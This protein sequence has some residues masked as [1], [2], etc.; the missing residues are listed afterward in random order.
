MKAEIDEQYSAYD[1]FIIAGELNEQFY[2]ENWFE[3]VF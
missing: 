1:G 2:L 3:T